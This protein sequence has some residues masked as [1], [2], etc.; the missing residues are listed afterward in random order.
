MRPLFCY[1]WGK[2]SFWREVNRVSTE[3]IEMIEVMQEM[4]RGSLSAF[5]RFYEQ[6]ASFVLQIAQRVTGDRMEA[7]DVCHDVLLHVLQ[8]AEG[9]DPSRGS[10]EAW[11]AVTTRNRALDRLRRKQ[12]MQ[13]SLLEEEAEAA[14]AAAG[15][16]PPVEDSVVAKL[17]GETLKNALQRIPSMQAKAI[18]GYY[19][20]AQSQRELSAELQVPLGTVKSLVRYGLHNLRKQLVQL[21]WSGLQKGKGA[22]RHE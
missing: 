12:R 16:F 18:A 8:K 4:S 21:G 13:P 2:E 1:I 22:K 14:I 19:L 9:F 15:S 5:R 6:Y 20:H 3:H 11:L 17:D 10:I 7:E